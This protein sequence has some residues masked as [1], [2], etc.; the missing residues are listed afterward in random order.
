MQ[1]PHHF[2]SGHQGDC[3]VECNS[4]IVDDPAH[5]T[6][7]T[8]LEQQEYMEHDP[9]QIAPYIILEQQ[10]YVQHDTTQIAPYT[11]LE[12]QENVQHDL[13][14]PVNLDYDMKLYVLYMLFLEINLIIK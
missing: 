14:Q 4:E 5:V 10:E 12:Q 6:Q 3:Q 9:A 8:I 13:S 7:Y 11:I 1:R 2:E